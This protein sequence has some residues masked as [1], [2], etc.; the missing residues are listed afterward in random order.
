MDV[1]SE[2]SGSILIT[3]TEVPTQASVRESTLERFSCETGINRTTSLLVSVMTERAPLVAE[4]Y[5]ASV[6]RLCGWLFAN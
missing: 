2:R 3:L 1:A 4:R 5:W 6:E